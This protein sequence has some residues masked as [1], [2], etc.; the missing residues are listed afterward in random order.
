[1]RSN[2]TQELI[3]RYKNIGESPDREQV[4]Q[5]IMLMEYYLAD[6]EVQLDTSDADPD[7]EARLSK[8]KID[9]DLLRD[10]VGTELPRAH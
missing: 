8:V 2:L 7:A 9:L 10:A 5:V 4:L 3:T 6:L 1:M